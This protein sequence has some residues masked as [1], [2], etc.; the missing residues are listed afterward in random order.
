MP[1]FAARKPVEPDW[2]CRGRRIPYEL[3]VFPSPFC[4]KRR[5][6]DDI[7][8]HVAACAERGAGYRVRK[9]GWL[10][11]FGVVLKGQACLLQRLRHAAKFWPPLEREI[12]ELYF[13]DHLALTDIVLI[14]GCTP[15]SFHAHLF[16]ILRRLRE[17]LIKEALAEAAHKRISFR[18][19]KASGP[20]DRPFS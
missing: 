9:M 20:H 8:T 2:R 15:G 11:W 13:V 3:N 5:G 10:S 19:R 6:L 1:T 12:F 4:T 17:E 7:V 16:F 14:A 18:C